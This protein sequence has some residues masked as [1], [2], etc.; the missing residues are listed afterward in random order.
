MDERKYNERRQ[1]YEIQQRE[2]KIQSAVDTARNMFVNPDEKFKGTLNAVGLNNF[3][4]GG[5]SKIFE[6]DAFKNII[7]SIFDNINNFST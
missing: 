7:G 2:I 3:D 1:N 6:T 5:M 4:M